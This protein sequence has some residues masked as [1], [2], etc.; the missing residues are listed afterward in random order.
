MKVLSGTNFGFG[1]MQF[2][3]T[4]NVK[5]CLGMDSWRHLSCLIS[6]VIVVAVAAVVVVVASHR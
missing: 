2:L 5:I 3:F 1:N 4:F 6:L